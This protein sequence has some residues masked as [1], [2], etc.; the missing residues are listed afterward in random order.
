MNTTAR[1]PSLTPS[2]HHKYEAPITDFIGFHRVSKKIFNQKFKLIRDKQFNFEKNYE[3]DL[4]RSV[5]EPKSVE[6]P[7]K[8]VSIGRLNTMLTLKLTITS[9]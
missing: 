9:Q 3:N 6:S 4:L 8:F 1:L 7:I 2:S 5:T